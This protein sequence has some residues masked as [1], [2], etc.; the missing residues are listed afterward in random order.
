MAVRFRLA[1]VMAAFGA[2]LNACGGG[3]GGS[4]PPPPPATLHI[5]QTTL[6]FH[7]DSPVASAPLSQDVTGSV[8]GTVSGVLYIVVQ[9]S[10][11]NVLTVS[12]FVVSGTSGQATVSVGGPNRLGAGTFNELLIIHACVNDATCATGELA[13]SPA[14][15]QVRY[16][17]G[18][19]VQF[20]TVT[21][22]VIASQTTS[23]LILRGQGFM[24]MPT[25]SIGGLAATAVTVVS[26]SEIHLT[27]PAL[28]AGPQTVL[29][30]N[31]NTAFTGMV[32]VVDDTAL[33]ST[34]I[35]WPNIP[36]NQTKHPE[37]LLYEPIHRVLFVVATDLSGSRYLHRFAYSAGWSRTDSLDI[38]Q[39]TDVKLSP[40]GT[41]LFVVY[42]DR[43]EV[44]DSTSLV[45]SRAVPKPTDPFLG[46]EDLGDMVI[47][48]DGMALLAWS[49]PNSGGGPVA[50]MS[51]KDYSIYQ[52]P[53]NVDIMNGVHPV[54]SR[55]GSQ[56]MLM[57]EIFYNSSTGLVISQPGVNIYPQYFPRWLTMVSN[58]VTNHL[59]LLV[60]QVVSATD[61]NLILQDIGTI[62]LP[63]GLNLPNNGAVA[64]GRAFAIDGNNLLHAWDIA[65]APVAGQ[66][67]EVVTPIDVSMLNPGGY[68]INLRSPSGRTDFLCNQFGVAVLAEN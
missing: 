36:D 67:A 50:I 18:S 5:N 26:D 19:S 23:T 46:N 64:I 41:L 68:W 16:T 14:V 51:L 62:S 55:D 29:I 8:T 25:I 37:A 32:D 57:A 47:T 49:G 33:P 54:V 39:S 59:D 28:P 60:Q 2:L 17:V 40:D 66:F 11:G 22:R 65:T 9:V 52:A 15:V 56:A 12:D 58:N 31:G 42:H 21:P 13:G 4:P 34:V 35:P 38:A 61:T 63:T 53:G 44:R 10:N 6:T 43:I 7:A 24:G 45:V 1:A 3:G 30:D 27:A 20:D 48:N